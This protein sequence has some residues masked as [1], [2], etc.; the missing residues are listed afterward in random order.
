M[1]INEFFISPL[2][3][4][5]DG[6]KTLAYFIGVQCPVATLGPGQAPQNVGWVYKN[7]SKTDIE[8]DAPYRSGKEAVKK[9]SSRNELSELAS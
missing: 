4:Y 7:G 2:Y 5:K 6:K 1:F 3:T 9:I 8:G